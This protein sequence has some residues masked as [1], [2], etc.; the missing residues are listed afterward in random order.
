[1]WG[2]SDVVALG[3]W[4]WRRGAGCGVGGVVPLLF[5]DCG[6][7]LCPCDVCACAGGILTDKSG[8]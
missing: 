2:E 5:E 3:V 7:A 8:K 6:G 1:M 4:D